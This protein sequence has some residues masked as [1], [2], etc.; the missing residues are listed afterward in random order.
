MSSISKRWYW[1]RRTRKA[2]YPI[3]V[4]EAADTVTFLTVWHQ[5]EVDDA[6]GGEALT[7]VEDVSVAGFNSTFDLLD[8]FRFPD[9]E[10]A[11]E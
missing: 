2:L 5:E 8:S 7:S 1:D 4:D 11:D 9:V 10:G 6:L 3:E